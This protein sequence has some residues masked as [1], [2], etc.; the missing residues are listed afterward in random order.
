MKTNIAHYGHKEGQ[1]YQIPENATITKSAKSLG[2]MDTRATFQNT[3]LN[4]D[5]MKTMSEE[6]KTKSSEKPLYY[7]Y[8]CN[9]TADD[10]YNYT[11]YARDRHGIT[12]FIDHAFR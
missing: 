1:K 6:R 10:G 5:E 7:I 11:R 8:K 9:E 2:K 3:T 4:D 12:C